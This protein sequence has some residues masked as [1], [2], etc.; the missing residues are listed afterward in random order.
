MNKIQVNANN[1]F[2]CGPHNPIGLRL[3][4]E[5]QDDICLSHFTPESNHC[6]YDGITH[7]GIIFSALDDVMANWLFLKGLTAFTAKCEIRYRDKLQIGE[8][9][10]LEGRCLKR[11]ARLTQMQG[12]L[13]HED[14]NQ[15][16]AEAE[17][18]F[19]VSTASTDSTDVS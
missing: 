16:I 11:K 5:I 7:G 14:K 2:V 6:G 19:M 9:V 12:L 15:I 17:A 8:R 3:S 10:R 18:T 13:I 1:C 4:F